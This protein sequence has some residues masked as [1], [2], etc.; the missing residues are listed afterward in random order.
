MG[1][2]LFFKNYKYTAIIF[3]TMF[4]IYGIYAIATNVAATDIAI[5]TESALCFIPGNPS[6][7]LC[8]L[9]SIGAGT[10]LL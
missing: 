8:D 3:L 5:T 10:K 4:I 2:V 6:S 7:E 9:A 1:V